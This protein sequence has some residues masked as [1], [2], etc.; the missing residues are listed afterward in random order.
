MS[1]GNTKSLHN[2]DQFTA[3]EFWL[4]LNRLMK[5]ALLVW[6]AQE[7]YSIS[8]FFQKPRI[9]SSKLFIEEKTLREGKKDR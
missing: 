6:S 8:E 2:C 3:K 5:F 7:W 1:F 4:L 9:R